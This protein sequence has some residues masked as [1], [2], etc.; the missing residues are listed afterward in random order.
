M[1]EFLKRLFG[2]KPKP[3]PKKYPWRDYPGNGRRI[4]PRGHISELAASKMIYGKPYR[5][6]DSRQ[7]GKL[8]P[9]LTPTIVLHPRRKLRM[10]SYPKREVLAVAA[11][12]RHKRDTSSKSDTSAQPV[13]A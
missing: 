8:P 4:R 10:I 1:I 12:L 2:V 11:E 5:L 7:R 9:G 6:R 3:R 13:S